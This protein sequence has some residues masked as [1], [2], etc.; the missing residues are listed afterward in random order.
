M[1]NLS[2]L[3]KTFVD[4]IQNE[5]SN[6]ILIEPSHSNYIPIILLII[7]YIIFMFLLLFKFKWLEKKIKKIIE[8]I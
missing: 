4:N 6:I 8:N 3:N 2:N 1:L 7:G 5:Y